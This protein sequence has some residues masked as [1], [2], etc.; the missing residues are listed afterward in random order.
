MRPY[1][2]ANRFTDTE[3][4]ATTEG[5]I[6]AMFLVLCFALALWT[7]DKYSLAMGVSRDVRTELWSRASPGCDDGAID[8]NLVGAGPGYESA[9]RRL[10]PVLS[11]YHDTPR[12]E[13][14]ESTGRGSRTSSG[15]LGRI[16]FA[17]RSELWTTCNE[18]PDTP[19]EDLRWATIDTYCRA[20]EIVCTPEQ[21]R[22]LAGQP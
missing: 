17:Y 3:G 2:R 13:I 5:V 20:S 12:I 16:P 1:K 4:S 19:E 10:A 6:V 9:Q 14:I 7:Y 11:P 21:A 18:L 8:S 15:F 22:E